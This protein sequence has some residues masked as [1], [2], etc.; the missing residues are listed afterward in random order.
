[1]RQPQT[2]SPDKKSMTRG[3]AAGSTLRTAVEVVRKV[4]SG[5]SAAVLS[6][7]ETGLRRLPVAM[8]D[9][10]CILRTYLVTFATF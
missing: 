8:E 7:G 5:G 6:R 10:E 4:A 1:M 9:K 2:G 3:A